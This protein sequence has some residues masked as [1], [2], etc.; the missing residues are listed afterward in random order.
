M[1]VVYPV[2]MSA[3]AVEELDWHP[4]CTLSWLLDVLIRRIDR[5]ELLQQDTAAGLP[6]CLLSIKPL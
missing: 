3:R 1:T 5:S 4:Q 6:E 2:S